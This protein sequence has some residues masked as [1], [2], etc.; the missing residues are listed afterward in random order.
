MALTINHQTNDISN[1]TGTI[2]VNGVAVGG[3]NTPRFWYG[4][5]GVF[6]GGYDAVGSGFSN[7]IDYIT[8][9]STGNA[10]DFGNLVAERGRSPFGISDGSRGVVGGGY[11]YTTDI[12]YFTVATLANA[13]DFG[14]LTTGRQS[15]ASA[16]DGVKG[17]IIA[18]TNSSN[19]GITN[20]EKITIATTGNATS[21][22]GT[23]PAAK[24]P[25]G[26]SNG[27]RAVFHLGI[28]SAPSFAIVNTIE[29]LSIQTEGNSTD[30]GDMTVTIQDRYSTG[31]TVRALFAGGAGPSNV[32]DYVTMATAGNATDFGDLT[33]AR[34]QPSAAS[35]A[36]R[37]TIA[38]GYSSSTR[39]NTIDYVT[40]D[41]TGNAIDFGDLTVARKAMAG[42][43]GT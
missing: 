22:S 35:N 38:G 17:I 42:L 8:I 39:Y 24:P 16:S 43:S 14:D 29:Y 26:W 6:A 20:V 37:A 11:N 23:V 30:F 41:T 33:V 5:R 1:A 32:I 3:D 4:S 18:G 36:V 10:T 7:V 15:P 2:L 13:V 27:D 12:D 40:I 19:Q 31:S 34:Q 21:Y 25:Q 9:A 28:I